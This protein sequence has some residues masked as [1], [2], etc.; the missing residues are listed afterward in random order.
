MIQLQ[1]NGMTCAA[2]SARVE[3]ALLGV[4]GVTSASVNLLTNS[5]QV[6]GSVDADSLIASVRRAG[7]NAKTSDASS[8]GRQSSATVSE[9]FV[10]HE[11]RNRVA[12]SALLVAALFYFAMGAPMFHW[13][14][15]ELFS[16]PGALATTQMI[17]ASLVIFVNRRLFANGYVSLFRA[18]PNMNTLV[19]LGASASFLYSVATLYLILDS[20][21]SGRLSSAHELTH[22][23]YF[24]SSADILFFISLGKLLEA[25]AKGQTTSALRALERLVPDTASVVRNG[26]EIVVP[27]QEVLV[28]DVF[29]VRSGDR[30]PVDGL[31]LE[32]SGSLDESALTGE[33]LPLEKGVGAE[34]ASGTLNTSGYLKCRAIRVGAD[35]SLSRIIQLTVDAAS[36]T[37]PVARLADKIS[38]VFVPVILTLSLITLVVWV[39]LGA[40]FDYALTRAVSVLVISCPC[41][42]GLAT[43]AAIMVGVGVG[44]RNGILFKTAEALENVG[45]CGVIALDKTGVITEGRPRVMEIYVSPGETSIELLRVAAAL[46]TRSEHPLARAVVE[47][48][49]GKLPEDAEIQDVTSF[50][51]LS[52]SGAYATVSGRSARIGKRR[53]I[54]EYVSIPSKV[55]EVIASWETNGWTSILV[56]RDGAL[57]GAFALADA[58]KADSKLAISNLQDSGA[59]VVM[60]TGDAQ[61]VADAVGRRVGITEI[62]ARATP[63]DKESIVRGLCENSSVAF[64]GDGIND[65][66]A[67]TRATVGVSVGSGTEVALAAADVALLE[68]RVSDMFRAVVLSRRTLRIIKENLFWAFFY[69]AL[70]IPLAAGFFGQLFGWNMSPTFAAL[71]MSLSSF[72]VVS[73]ALRLNFVKLPGRSDKVVDADRQFN[74][75]TLAPIEENLM[76]KTMKIEGMMCGHC[77]ARVK[78]TLEALAFVASADVDHNAGTAIVS[79]QESPEN[80]DELL[81]NAVDEQ[82]YTTLSID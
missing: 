23:L 8:A 5:A 17:L 16:N 75:Q 36:S 6:E 30:V 31:V 72:C 55:D 9:D 48:S 82:G 68:S 22:S 70:G 39:L 62:Y 1:V 2:C 76:T 14:L 44:A 63:G 66:P 64:V 47:Y 80:V 34:V 54:G 29:I 15:P 42:L 20:L 46:E 60:I 28:D 69:N 3:K 4:P 57:L 33:S 50:S 26:V 59:R 81:K 51:T 79:L 27:A 71:A 13:P 52:G 43:P 58:E 56:E 78:K 61:A 12:A 11:L 32:G 49:I 35:M 45:K 19:A 37:A 41:A 67:L 7:Y 53:F 73:N 18:S 38:R 77:E 74:K 40:T 65:A 10:V 21:G 25:R 24:E